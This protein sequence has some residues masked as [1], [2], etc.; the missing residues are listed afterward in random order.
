M[1]ASLFIG[2]MAAGA[3]L[4]LA[5]PA[6]G[7]PVKGTPFPLIG[8]V[9][10]D[11][12]K[13]D[14]PSTDVSGIAC[15]PAVAGRQRCL[16]V[17]DEDAFAQWAEVSE[18][19][20]VPGDFIRVVPKDAPADILGTVPPTACPKPDMRWKDLDG[21]AVAYDGAFFYVTGSHG[22]GRNNGTFT[23]SS[24]VLARIAVNGD[25]SP[26]EAKP[27][28]SHRLA[29]V[30]AQAETVAPY[31]G[32]RLEGT[33]DAN[34]L[35]IEGLAVIGADLYAGLR[36]PVINGTAFLI[37]TPVAPLFEAGNPHLSSHTIPLDLGGRGV[38]DLAPLPDGRLLVLA[39]P[40]RN[41]PESG[42]RLTYAIYAVDPGKAGAV[43]VAELAMPDPGA[44]AEA[45]LPL[46]PF[47]A[48]RILVLFD[49]A[50]GGAPHTYPISIP[51]R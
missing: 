12:P 47:P 8:G 18:Q 13:A 37:K 7:Q 33:P 46:G 41:Q 49:G 6:H 9:F 29:E 26:K 34:G 2:L 3:G 36:A 23:I 35:N 21:E 50:A 16:V 27:L 32:K 42:S 11:K 1:R 5:A 19:G 40:P 38:R 51:G 20:L 24:F 39:G 28:R 15:A 45:L 43:P 30:L 22:C 10:R 25:G 14:A 48:G 4:C 31:A 44:K 17:A